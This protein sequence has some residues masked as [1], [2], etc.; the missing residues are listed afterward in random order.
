MDGVEQPGPEVPREAFVG[1]QAFAVD[2]VLQRRFSEGF[3][4]AS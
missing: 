4:R 2:L 1:E 3:G